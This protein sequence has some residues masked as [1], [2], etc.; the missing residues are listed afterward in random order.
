MSYEER[1]EIVEWSLIKHC[2]DCIIKNHEQ[3]FDMWLECEADMAFGYGYQYMN[4]EINS[5]LFFAGTNLL[6]AIRAFISFKEDYE[7]DELLNF[8]E[9]FI[10][11]QLGAFDN[12]CE[13]ISSAM[14]EETSEYEREN[15]KA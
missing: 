14:Y 5:Q 12:W 2:K 1:L 13:D 11:Q 6:Y 3:M 10:E 4:H 8:T 15:N 9:K 7:L